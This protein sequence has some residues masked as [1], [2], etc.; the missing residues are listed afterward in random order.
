[1]SSHHP[2][3]QGTPIVKNAREQL[4]ILTTYQELGSYR[5]T[6][7]LCG[8]THKTVRRVIERRSRP[9]LERPPRPKATDPYLDLI[10]KRIEDTKGKITAKRL[11]PPCRAKGYDGSDR[12]LR[13]AVAIARAAYRRGRRD[14]RPWDPVPGEHLVF[15]WGEVGPLK[16]FCAVLAWSRWRFVRFAERQDQATTLR[17]LTECFELLGGVTAPQRRELARWVGYFMHRKAEQP[18]GPGCP[19]RIVK[20]WMASYP[21]IGKPM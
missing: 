18:S 13:R 10:A 21:S 2:P 20:R 9:L 16:V 11:L 17:L 3:P 12:S 4:A 6:A 7:T 14:Y 15:D 8:T 19:H 5:A 1:M